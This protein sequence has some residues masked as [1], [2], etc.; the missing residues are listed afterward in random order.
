[1][2]VRGRRDRNMKESEH[3]RS[4]KKASQEGRIHLS[5]IIFGSRVVSGTI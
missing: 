2:M 1:M 3:T 4:P 5:I